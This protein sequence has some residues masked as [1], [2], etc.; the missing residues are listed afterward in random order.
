VN[1][2]D[3]PPS[4]IRG[5]DQELFEA[6]D[7]PEKEERMNETKTYTIPERNF[8]KQAAFGMWVGST[9]RDHGRTMQVTAIGKARKEGRERLIDIFAIEVEPKRQAAS[10]TAAPK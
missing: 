4:V 7:A 2:P 10:K 3:W 8:L 1:A 6:G 9:F 5:M